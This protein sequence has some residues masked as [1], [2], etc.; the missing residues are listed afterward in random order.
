MESAIR[1]ASRVSQQSGKVSNRTYLVR[2]LLQHPEVHSACEDMQRFEVGY[3][4]CSSA[5]KFELDRVKREKRYVQRHQIQEFRILA[6][7]QH[8]THA[9]NRR[10]RSQ[11]REVRSPGRPVTKLHWHVA[12]LG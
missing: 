8:T 9:Q 3:I 6:V 1:T 12:E 4:G 5:S 10:R 11:H 7:H 2:T